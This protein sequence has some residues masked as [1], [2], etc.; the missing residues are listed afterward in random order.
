MDLE[1]IIL[2]A[3]KIGENQVTLNMEKK[4]ERITVQQ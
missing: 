4:Q 1:G 3:S 2:K